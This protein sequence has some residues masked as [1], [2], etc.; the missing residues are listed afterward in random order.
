MGLVIA[1]TI[2]EAY[3]GKIWLDSEPEGPAFRFALP[4]E[5]TGEIHDREPHHITH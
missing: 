3:Q 2:A 5:A 4:F 1:R